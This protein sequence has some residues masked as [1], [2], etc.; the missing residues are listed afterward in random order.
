[1]CSGLIKPEPESSK[2][3]ICVGLCTTEQCV[4]AHQTA[5]LQHPS[6][7]K[8]LQVGCFTGKYAALLDPVAMFEA[9]AAQG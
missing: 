8:C 1:M 5:T 3:H 4:K 2:S 7:A 6:V 9:G